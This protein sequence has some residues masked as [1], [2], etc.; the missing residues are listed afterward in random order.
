MN[1]LF[2]KFTRTK[3]TANMF[4]SGSGLGLYIG[5]NFVEAHGGRI[6]AESEGSGKG[7]R[8]II[9]LPFVN[10]NVKIGVSEQFSMLG[11]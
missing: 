8:F 9:E 4:V 3:E 2:E 6:W 11:R 1:K 5:K 10:P 7:S